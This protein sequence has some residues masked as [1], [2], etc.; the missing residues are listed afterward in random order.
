MK[1]L[2]H[3][4]LSSQF[5]KGVNV[6]YPLLLS[7]TKVE[8]NDVEYNDAFI[9]RMIPKLDYPALV[10]AAKSVVQDNDLPDELV[11]DWETNEVFL[12][13][14]NALLL[15]V[16]VIDGELQ[17][18]ETGRKFMIRSSIPNMLVNSNEVNG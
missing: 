6:G 11:Q 16:E 17:C 3:N 18:P 5:L 1:L 4:F 8:K 12:K 2:T 10:Q 9:K 13:K 7:A 14:V 15:G